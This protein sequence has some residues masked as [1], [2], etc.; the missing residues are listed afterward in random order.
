M[1]NGDLLVKFLEGHNAILCDN[2]V[3][4]AVDVTSISL[5]FASTDE[6]QGITIEGFIGNVAKRELLEYDEV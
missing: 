2:G 3:Y 5:D 4:I 6:V 1:V